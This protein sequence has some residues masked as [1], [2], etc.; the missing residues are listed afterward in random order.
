MCVTDTTNRIDPTF[1]VRASTLRVRNATVDL[2]T[3]RPSTVRDDQ[4]NDQHRSGDH[5]IDY[6]YEDQEFD[7]VDAQEAERCATD[8]TPA[9]EDVEQ[10]GLANG[11]REPPLCAGQDRPTDGFI[12]R[13]RMANR[14][15]GTEF[16]FGRNLL[17]ENAVAII[18]QCFGLHHRDAQQK[19]CPP[20][21]SWG[22]CCVNQYVTSL[23][24][25]A[26]GV[27]GIPSV[28]S[29]DRY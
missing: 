21:S 4:Y 29:T 6:G 1:D 20:L 15:I 3:Q 18:L 26:R 12:A 2:I 13:D 5:S 25:P 9:D 8:G 11:S 22:Q 28:L 17:F 14:L 16:H 19:Y 24:D 27:A 10:R 23:E 7:W